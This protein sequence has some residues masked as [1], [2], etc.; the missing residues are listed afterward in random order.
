MAHLRAK[1]RFALRFATAAFGQWKWSD[2]ELL[3][4]RLRRPGALQ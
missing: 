2:D 3:L 1:A 4:R